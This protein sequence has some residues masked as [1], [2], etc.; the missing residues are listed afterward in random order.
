MTYPL[1]GAEAGLAD[2]VERDSTG[3]ASETAESEP[4]EDPPLFSTLLA[5]LINLANICGLSSGPPDPPWAEELILIAQETL[6]IKG[7]PQSRQELGQFEVELLRRIFG[8]EN[9][10]IWRQFGMVDHIG[11]QRRGGTW[12]RWVTRLSVKQHVRYPT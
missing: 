4:L 9:G 11:F 7:Y 1:K 3:G 6:R 8:A 5:L 10:W 12:P 2:V